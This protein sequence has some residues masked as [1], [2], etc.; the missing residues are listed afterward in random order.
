MR[1]DTLQSWLL[2]DQ[3]QQQDRAYRSAASSQSVIRPPAAGWSPA[4]DISEQATQFVLHADLPGVDPAQIE[5]TLEKGALTL[6]GSRNLAERTAH[7]GF[8]CIERA[9][10][11]FHRRFNLPDTADCQAVKARYSNGVLEVLI[12]KQAQ[13][14]ARRV[15]V[16]AA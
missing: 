9:T 14:V 11:A 8:R 10:G 4:V 5:V 15:T 13:T 12:P 16:E 3:L 2:M 1:I 7:E 6:S